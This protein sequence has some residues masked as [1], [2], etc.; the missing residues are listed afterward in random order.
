[1]D[2]DYPAANFY[3]PSLICPHQVHLKEA[4]EKLAALELESTS[5][6]QIPQ[7]VY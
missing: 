4:V 7:G 5:L 1:M 2:L 6:F 3:R